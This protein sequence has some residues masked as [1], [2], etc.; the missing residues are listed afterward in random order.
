MRTGRTPSGHPLKE[1]MPWNDYSHMTDKELKA[2][3]LYLQSLPKREQA[4]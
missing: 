4:K 1:D 2:I 3:W